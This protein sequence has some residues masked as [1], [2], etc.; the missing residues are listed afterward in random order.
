MTTTQVI[1]LI[2]LGIYLSV[3]LSSS[4]G[5]FNWILLRD[6]S[7]YQ[8]HEQDKFSAGTDREKCPVA[9]VSGHDI[10]GWGVPMQLY[11]HF[12]TVAH[13]IFAAVIAVA[14]P[15]L[16]FFSKKGGPLHKKIGYFITIVLVIQGFGGLSSLILQAIRQFFIMPRDSL[17][18]EWGYVLPLDSKFVFLPMFAAGFVTPIMNGLGK[19]VLKIPYSICAIITLLVLIYDVGYAYPVMIRRMLKHSSDTYDFQILVELLAISVLYPFQDVGNLLRYYAH[20]VKGE[21]MDDLAQHVNNTKILTAVAYTAITWFTSHTRIYDGDKQYAIPTFYR[22][23]VCLIPCL[24]MVW[25]GSFSSYVK[26]MY[27]MKDKAKEE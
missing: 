9:L 12:I 7:M 27:G 4:Y 8:H 1:F 24:V 23:V 14:L 15:Y 3:A 25:T 20:F 16:V 6:D 17:P 2:G 10:C 19:W 5:L 21:K 26:Y 22:I 13:L 11:R 18:P